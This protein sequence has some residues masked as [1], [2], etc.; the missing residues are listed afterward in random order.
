LG[1]DDLNTVFNHMVVGEYQPGF[2]EYNPCT[3]VKS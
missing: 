3:T 1:H 2:V